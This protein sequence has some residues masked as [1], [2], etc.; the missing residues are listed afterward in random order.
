MSAIGDGPFTSFTKSTRG[1]QLDVTHVKAKHENEPKGIVKNFS[2]FNNIF[3]YLYRK[4]DQ[5]KSKDFAGIN[6]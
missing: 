2:I 3:I 1:K 5:Q 4:T 6:R